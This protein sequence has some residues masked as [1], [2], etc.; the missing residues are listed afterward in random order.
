MQAK[1]ITTAT[2]THTNKQA[3]KKN[4]QIKIRKLPSIAKIIQKNKQTKHEI[5]NRISLVFTSSS[6][7]FFVVIV[8]FVAR[9]ELIL[10]LAQH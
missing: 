6:T 5:I 9:N 10:A 3:N 1:E 2:H 8:V 7:S 4:E